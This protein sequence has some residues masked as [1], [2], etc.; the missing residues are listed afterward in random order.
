MPA[1]LTPLCGNSTPT[2]QEVFEWPAGYGAIAVV[3]IGTTPV[4]Q[5]KKRKGD[6]E[7][8]WLQIQQ[9]KRN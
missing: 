5:Q 2:G 1:A 9:I 8:A 6:S 7:R 3:V 4:A